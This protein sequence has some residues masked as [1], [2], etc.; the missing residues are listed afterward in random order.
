MCEDFEGDLFCI[1]LFF[2]F[3][4]IFVWTDTEVEP[5]NEVLGRNFQTPDY[6]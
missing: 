6:I 1:I 2:Y 3:S 4:I 5:M